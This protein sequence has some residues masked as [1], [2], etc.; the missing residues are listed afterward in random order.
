MFKTKKNYEFDEPTTI[1]D[2]EYRLSPNDIITFYLYTNDGFRIIDLQSLGSTGTDGQNFNRNNN[3]QV[4]YII[5]E[6][7]YVKL[8]S[9]RR[10][11]LAGMTVDE[12]EYFLE[13]QYSRDYIKPFVIPFE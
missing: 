2:E 8:P 6:D 13:E 9:L 7:G 10:V 1:T 11:K 3:F 4:R 12:A 5:E